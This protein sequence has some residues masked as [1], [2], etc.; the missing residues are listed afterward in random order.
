MQRVLAIIIAFCLGAPPLPA[1]AVARSLRTTSCPFTETA[2]GLR[3]MVAF[4]YQRDDP[5]VGKR[6]LIVGGSE[7]I[8]E[9]VAIHFAQAGA[10][11]AIAARTPDKLEA[12]I[13]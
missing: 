1:A 11:V 2:L 5:F 3:S 13:A 12:A 6:V 4:A 8:G 10:H 7:G 9:A